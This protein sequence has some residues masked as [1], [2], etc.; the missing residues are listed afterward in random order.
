[1]E[2]KITLNREIFLRLGFVPEVDEDGFETLVKNYDNGVTAVYYGTNFAAYKGMW[3]ILIPDEF[4]GNNITA[5]TEED[6][7]YLDRFLEGV[8]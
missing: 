8:I 2:K 6:I 5:A 1:M 7:I 4:Y 3:S